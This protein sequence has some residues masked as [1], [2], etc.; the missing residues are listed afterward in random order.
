MNIV[1]WGVEWCSRN[2]L[3][4]ETRYLM[5]V[6]TNQPAL[7]STRKAAREWITKEYGYIRHRRD[8]REEPHGWRMPRAVRVRLTGAAIR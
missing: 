1:R 4:G 5:F 8:L 6:T 7:F 3:N 2:A